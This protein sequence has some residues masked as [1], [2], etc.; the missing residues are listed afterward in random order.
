MSLRV[1]DTRRRKKLPFEPVRPNYAGMYVCGMTVQ[2]KPHVGHMRYAVAGDVIRRYLEFKGF[3]VTYVTNFTDIDDRIIDRA[4]KEGI[5]FGKVS[6]RNMKAF[7][8]YADLLNIKRATHYPRATEHI[9]E[10][11][12]LIQ[13]LIQKGHAYAAGQDVYFEV[14]SYSKY[15]ELSRRKLDDLRSGVRIEVG[16]AKRDPLD[17]TLWKGVKPSEP[18]W[19]SP[20]GPGRP[21]WHIECSAMAMKYLGETFDF[22]GGG[23]DL[24]F[25]HHENEIAQSEAATGKT[26]ACYWIENGLVLLRGAKMSKSDQHF[27]LIEDVAKK[28]EP[29]VIRFYLQ[30]TQYRS[31]IEWNE[32]RLREAGI[33]YARLRAALK[34]GEEAG[35]EES[36][37]ALKSKGLHGESLKAEK[38]FEEAMD[39]DFN[40]AKAQGHLFD[41]AKAINRV[42]ESGAS[43]PERAALPHATRTLRRLGETLGLFWEGKPR[44]EEVPDDVQLLVRQRDEARLQKQWQRADEL[45]D[46]IQTLGYVLDDQKGGTRARRKL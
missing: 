2:D 40:S 13:R 28:V 25:P 29:E 30:S 8:T 14:R 6:E 3:E 16:E 17:F 9:P 20:W 24:V 43:G 34:T 38:L 35:G 5:P 1:Y 10:I 15:G 36:P 33:A 19:P 26:F 42:A 21:G 46:Q 37:E 23:Q 27:F 4:N 39:D 44:E 18:S 11:T 41:L 12:A 31:P 45:R 7:I 22:H 32:D